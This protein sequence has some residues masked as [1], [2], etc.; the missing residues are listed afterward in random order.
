MDL[1]EVGYLSQ[2]YGVIDE[3]RESLD[4][5]VDPASLSARLQEIA[6]K[7]LDH[8][9]QGT[10]EALTLIAEL[11]AAEAQANS[12]L[13]PDLTNLLAN[14]LAALND[15]SE[16]CSVRLD[17]LVSGLQSHVWAEPLAAE[18]LEL[19]PELLAEDWSRF[20]SCDQA[21]LSDSE[22]VALSESEPAAPAEF[23]SERLAA[24]AE[25]LLDRSECFSDQ[26]QQALADLF[27]LSAE[28]LEQGESVDT[29]TLSA[30]MTAVDALEQPSLDAALHL[31]DLLL[32]P[33]WDEPIDGDDA[34]DLRALLKAQFSET[35]HS[36]DLAAG[37]GID[38]E[39]A[40]VSGS[41]SEAG[42]D[43][44]LAERI[45]QLLASSDERSEE[46]QQALAD[47]F[48][49]SAD[50]LE[51][52]ESA[53]TPAVQALLT[54]LDQLEQASLSAALTVLDLLAQPGWQE[55]LDPEDVDDLRVLLEQQFADDKQASAV[56][57]APAETPEVTVDAAPVPES[58]CAS[59]VAIDAAP[60]AVDEA[61]V[62]SRVSPDELSFC[63]VDLARLEQPGA[64][65]DEGILAMLAGSLQALEDQ[66][67]GE[68]SDGEVG[69]LVE[70]SIDAL[71][72][73][74][75]ACSTVSLTG[76]ELLIKGLLVNLDVLAGDAASV[77]SY[78]RQHIARTLNALHRY[79]DDL[80]DRGAR[81]TL[82]DC[83]SDEALPVPADI[84]Q[85]AFISGLLALAS[86]QSADDVELQT[87][88]PDD[89]DLAV[90]EGVDEQLLEML[91][92]E[93]PVLV[94]EFQQQL[95]AVIQQRQ[96]DGLLAAQRAAH[97]IKGLANMAGIRGVAN[98]THHLEDILE[99]LT[100]AELLP[101]EQLAQ[102]LNDASDCLAVMSEVVT[103][104]GMP[105]ESALAQLQQ[106][107]HW[108]YRLRT[109]GAETAGQALSDEERERRRE[110]AKNAAA[111]ETAAAP[112]NTP[113]A[114]ESKDS[115]QIRVPVSI[116]DNLFRIAGESSTLGTQLD[117]TL[118]EM[119]ALSRSNRDRQRVLQ[120][121]LFD[122]EQQLHDHFTLTPSLQEGE[123]DFDPLEMDR[124]HAMHTT[125]SQLQEAAADVREV[126]Q[127]SERQ[128]RQL[129]ELQVAQ[130]HLQK[131]SL[132]NVLGTRLV[133][134]R[135]LSSRMQRIMR[136]ACRAA[137]KQGQLL[138]EGE[139]V[140]VDSQILNQLADPLMHIIRNAV[141]HGLETPHLR[142]EA[143]KAETGTLK[144]TFA[145]AEGQVRV[146][147]EDDGAGIDVARV[148]EIAER[149]GLVDAEAQLSESE[150]QRL[151]L[152]PGFSTR[153]EISQLSGR[154]IG[155]DVVY[156]QV[157]RM[158]GT[159]NIH[160]EPGQGTRFELSMP[161]SS[162]LVHT[163]LVR[164]SGQRV[165]ALS[166][167]TIEQSLLSLDG[168]FRRDDEG[169]F[170]TL[171]GKEYPAFSLEGLVGEPVPDYSKLAIHPV[172]LVNLDQGEKA[173]VFLRE[174]MA[175]R[176][177]AFKEL[178]EHLPDIPGIPGV[179]ILANG[180][181]A[182]IV[183]LQARVR[184]CHSLVGE[185]AERLETESGSQLPRLLVVD[186]SLSARRTLATLL[187]DSGYEVVTAIDG[188]DA[189]DKVRRNPP[190]LVLT[191]LEMP[192][193]TGMEL[194]AMLNNSRDFGDIPVIMITSRSTR[195]HREEAESVGVS[196]YL[197]KPWSEAAVLEQVQQLLFATA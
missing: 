159:L 126:D 25:T 3:L 164:S 30:L 174:I 23:S 119:R 90:A 10:G 146:I 45:E 68:P 5:A 186:D 73:L 197:N 190:D 128:L 85:A 18:D 32:R 46:G 47:L 81:E 135:T 166:A 148:R 21:G 11:L 2:I 97:T 78:R 37:L 36:D 191:D 82:V 58:A 189:L 117:A 70:A 101:G 92:A 177:L 94:E 99:V 118:A 150:T 143:S 83:L 192:R 103:E 7:A 175:H 105:P 138:I 89:I 180:E 155:M 59:D 87:A 49:L 67:Q 42:S 62:E 64:S 144:I 108:Y 109:E 163:L 33:D 51:S 80:S 66:W 132:E 55:P 145:Q 75:R 196:A 169:T 76:V 84:Q 179:T 152:V 20:D 39:S 52:C 178:G 31:L 173:V 56:A 115:A 114:A 16:E 9:L 63:E 187:S 127:E 157:S 22:P 129:A 72:P 96:P 8:E 122:L 1:T 137:D 140:M 40:G 160:S 158:Q 131:E 107:M 185:V 194:A 111:E 170:F 151:I 95:Q 106:L 41:P 50:A 88:Q 38:E 98:L 79:L 44:A 53:E 15:P 181:V 113:A 133:P 48:A 120:R 93:L 130:S 147:C 142:F 110:E 139:E 195:K 60:V 125:L 17:T 69:E 172:L 100:D 124:Y 12:T 54:A 28:V 193:M 136:Q 134:A 61:D 91:Y 74:A 112:V 165:Y 161:A 121:V 182:P 168:Q 77:Y 116:L 171:E 154:G 162:L 176:E 183:D 102:D 6:D 188:L 4:S 14:Q 123:S 43:A 167:H 156:Q 71:Q 24:F 29:E 65:I 141:D 86:A 35:T 34:D 153:D 57:A 26:D 184:H 27:A 149:R 104:G 13:P 19:L